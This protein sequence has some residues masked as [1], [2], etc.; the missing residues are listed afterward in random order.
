MNFVLVGNPNAGKTT[1][2]NALAHAEEKTGNWHG[3]TV[4][5]AQKSVRFFG[6]KATF[7]DVPGLYSLSSY[8]MEE[9]EAVRTIE[10]HSADVIVQVVEAKTLPR[11]LLLTA[12]LAKKG[13]RLLLVVTMLSE[14]H[15]EL[16]LALLSERI[17]IPVL[18]ADV[19]H[20]DTE[21]LKNFLWEHRDCRRAAAFTVGRRE[22]FFRAGKHRENAVEKLCFHSVLWV[23]LF[24]VCMSVAFWLTFGT[25][26][27][28][29]LLK[30]GTE[31]L[32]VEVF[33]GFLHSK[34]VLTPVLSGLLFDGI[35]KG[36]GSVLSFVPQIVLLYFCLILMEESGYLSVLSFMA[37]GFL[38][39]IGLSGRAVFSLLMGFGCSAAAV[40]SS[41]AC[42]G[43]CEKR[44]VIASV[45]YLPCSAKLPVFLVVCSSVFARP[46]IA[47]FLLYFGGIVLALVMAR[48]RRK[49]CEVALASEV[50]S[51]RVPNA[52][53]VLKSLFFYAKGY[54]IKT[55]TVVFSFLVLSWFFSSFTPRLQFTDPEHSMLAYACRYVKFLFYPMGITDWKIVYAAL[56]GLVAKE[57]VAGILAV[58]YDEIPFD[59]PAAVAFSVFLLTCSPCVSAIAATAREL[60][61]KEALFAFVFQTCSSLLCGYLA[62]ACCKL[63][64]L[65]LLPIFAGVG[66]C[67]ERVYRNKKHSTERLHG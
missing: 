26:A 31:W 6:E 25:Y 2:F 18:A 24:L 65:L 60:G 62:F 9:G 40:L 57:N 23:P 64:F 32:I 8:S 43:D 44:T 1:L 52:R 61:W 22:D 33:G 46:L 13:Y 4:A 29:G 66:Y 27:P 10:A 51:L 56:S 36:V 19:L 35:I 15:G 47:V 20:G 28:G 5:T 54:I 17:G 14:F 37:D 55:A 11:A 34:L 63:P 3:V 58:F 49:K 59:V 45:P 42:G 30:R 7:Y 16:D 50:A 48:L 12:E 67:I 39:K 53:V 21:R 41:R 38:Q